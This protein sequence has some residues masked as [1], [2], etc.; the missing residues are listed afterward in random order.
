MK[1]ITFITMVLLVGFVI[2]TITSEHDLRQV[3]KICTTIAACTFL[4]MLHKEER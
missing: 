2:M 3:Y 1:N 4:L